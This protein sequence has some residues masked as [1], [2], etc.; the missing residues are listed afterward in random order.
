MSKG[1]R[2]ANRTRML[3][4]CVLVDESTTACVSANRARAVVGRAALSL[5]LCS[6]AMSLN[7]TASCEALDFASLDAGTSVSF[8]LRVVWAAH[9]SLDIAP[10][11]LVLFKLRTTTPPRYQ[12]RPNAG[13]IA[14]RPR[15][16]EASPLA[17]A[18]RV[19][20]APSDSGSDVECLGV[21]ASSS[22]DGVTILEGERAVH[23]TLRDDAPGKLRDKFQAD[24][25]CLSAGDG[26]ESLTDY[27]AAAHGRKQP[28]GR[29]DDVAEAR[30]VK[31]IYDRCDER[32]GRAVVSLTVRHADRSPPRADAAAGTAAPTG[33]AEELLSPQSV[34][35]A[36]ALEEE[37]ARKHA[38]LESICRETATLE[39]QVRAEEAACR[40][41]RKLAEDRKSAMQLA[42]TKALKT[43]PK[44]AAIPLWFIVACCLATIA[45]VLHYRPPQ[46]GPSLIDSVMQQF[47]TPRQ[48][49]SPV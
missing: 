7:A 23:I 18:S 3:A 40:D 49:Y 6:V 14:L 36:S 1:S 35:R 9:G 46:T 48:P 37:L 33:D 47:N 39:E 20:P 34:G 5:F 41:L 19:G 29:A 25:R 11:A 44:R 22:A 13:V 42:Q 26:A 17:G 28:G 43:P 30:A 32:L 8:T 38:E 24:F 12:V 45:V 10:P 15:G 2:A 4:M 16:G 27:S 21:S 31:G